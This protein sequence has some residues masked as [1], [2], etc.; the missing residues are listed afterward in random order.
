MDKIIIKRTP[1]IKG[2]YGER[3]LVNTKYEDVNN[4]VKLISLWT[5]NSYQD[6]DNNCMILYE[7]PVGISVK[8]DPCLQLAFAKLGVDFQD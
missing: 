8:T 4:F 5:N 7:L 3:L 1:M 2:C 6:E